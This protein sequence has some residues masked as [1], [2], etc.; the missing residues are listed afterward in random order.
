MSGAA[1]DY[2]Y[3]HLGVFGWTT[4][5]WDVVMAAT[6]RHTNTKVWYTGFTVEEQLAI[7]K[8]A[9]VNA[10]HLYPAWRKFDHPQLG[11]VE[12]GGPNEF[13]LFYNPPLQFLK[14]EVAPHASFAVHQVGDGRCCNCSHLMLKFPL[15]ALLSPKLEILHHVVEHIGDVV[16]GG[17][18]TSMWRI[19][20]GRH[21]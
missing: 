10:P 1:D 5:F 4:E 8:W 13:K 16:T 17:E 20:I 18:T 21:F 2:M 12:L 3:E 14:Q 15:K 6:G 11:E 19:K 7:A 9:D